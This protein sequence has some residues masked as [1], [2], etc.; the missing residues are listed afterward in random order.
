MLIKRRR[1]RIMCV[2]FVRIVFCIS[3]RFM[4][5][6]VLIIFFYVILIC[7]REG[8]EVRYVKNGN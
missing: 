8:I 2:C 1:K 4:G 5:G 3:V 7:L 6:I